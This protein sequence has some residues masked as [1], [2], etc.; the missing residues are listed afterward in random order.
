MK[1]KIDMR[2]VK[3]SCNEGKQKGKKIQRKKRKNVLSNGIMK[4]RLN[5]CLKKSIKVLGILAKPRST[6]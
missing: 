4:I 3:G 6:V 1:I 5:F 2:D